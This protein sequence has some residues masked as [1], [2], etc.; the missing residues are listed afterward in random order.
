MEISS[1]V[2]YIKA[3]LMQVKA[4]SWLRLKVLYNYYNNTYFV[5]EGIEVQ[6]DL[7]S[8]KPS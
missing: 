6:S 7:C 3:R 4:A 5:G 8:G 2:T 1:L